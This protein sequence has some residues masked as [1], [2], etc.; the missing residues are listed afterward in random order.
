MKKTRIMKVLQLL[1]LLV[2]C[3][4]FVAFTDENS[5]IDYF[6][7]QYVYKE[8]TSFVIEKSEEFKKLV[9]DEKM[10]EKYNDEYF[11]EKQIVLIVVP[12]GSND[13][14]INVKDYSIKDGVLT[15]EGRK[16]G[17]MYANCLMTNYNILVEIDD[18]EIKEIIVNIE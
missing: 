10:L 4:L 7:S 16:F 15:L 1:M 11:E 13:I 9:E 14:S 2:V 18:V 12:I 8:Q 17:P 6:K 3:S 5:G